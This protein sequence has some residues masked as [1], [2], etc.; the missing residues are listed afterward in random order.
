MISFLQ[1]SPISRSIIASLFL[2]VLAGLLFLIIFRW[3]NRRR[4]LDCLIPSLL[5]LTVGITAGCLMDGQ[6][7][8]SNGLTVSSIGQWVGNLPW[9]LHILILF[10]CVLYGGFV[11]RRERMTAKNE[12][13]P[14]SI[15]EALDNLPNGLCFS[16]EN[17]MPLLTNRRMYQ[18]AEEATGKFCRNAEVMWREVSGFEGQNGIVRLHNEDFPTFHWNDGKI[19]QFS[20]TELTLQNRSYIQTT[21]TDIT[22]LYRLTEELEKNNA[23]LDQKYKRL[24]NIMGEL[25]RITQEEEILASKVKVHKELGE[26]LLSARRHLMLKQPGRDIP[27]LFQQWQD[28]VKFVESALKEEKT[29]DYAMRE[30]MEAA[31]ALGCTITFEG[32]AQENAGGYPILKH[33]IREAMTN[34]IRHAG[35]NEMTVQ[36]HVQEDTLYA[37]IKNNGSRPITPISE[38]SGLSTLRSRIERAGGNMEIRCSDGVELHIEIPRKGDCDD[39]SI[40]CRRSADR[41]GSDGNYG[42][43]IK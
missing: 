31:E 13:T 15:R 20:R 8:L 36:M 24:K 27:E 32:G 22:R 43:T 42:Q 35:A 29:S 4:P 28:A 7:R 10:A 6:S 14:A 26:C 38:G 17:G 23:D 16:D 40:N 2:A 19:W 37:V 9:I 41:T 39:T 33:A 12:I 3:T 1:C 34:A 25:V 11:I 21:A 18:L 30:L 5:I